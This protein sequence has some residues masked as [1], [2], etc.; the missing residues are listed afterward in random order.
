ML[1]R[2]AFTVELFY[3]LMT[4]GAADSL[5]LLKLFIRHEPNLE[6]GSIHIFVLL[7]NIMFLT[8]SFAVELFFDFAD[9]RHCQ[10]ATS[11]IFS[12]KH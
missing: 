6:T 5:A 8:G 11:L 10:F 2:G 7:A 9:T 4:N 1:L 12:I 3:D